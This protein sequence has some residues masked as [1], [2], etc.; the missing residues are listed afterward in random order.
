MKITEIKECRICKSLRLSRFFDFGEQYVVDFLDT[1]NSP[2]RGK[3][4]LCLMFCEDCSLVQLTHTVESDT[5]FKKFWYRSGINESMINALRDV[6]IKA[7]DFVHLEKGD[8]VLDIGANDGTLLSFYPRF[9]HAVAVDPARGFKEEALENLYVDEYIEDYFS[10][11]LL[12][13]RKFKIITA[14]AMFYDLNDPLAFMREIA[15]ALD[16][17]GVCVIQQNYLLSMLDNLAFD[18]IS[19]EHICYHTLKTMRYLAEKA[20]LVV[21][22]MEE[23]EVNGGSFRLYLAH[24]NKIE[25]VNKEYFLEP[26][27]SEEELLSE[28]S[29]YNM[30]FSKYEEIRDRLTTYIQDIVNKGGC[31]FGYGA[32]TRGTTLLQAIPEVANALEGV[33]DRDPHKVGKYMVSGTLPVVSEDAARQLATHFFVLPYHF[34]EPIIKREQQWIDEGGTMIIPLPYLQII[35]RRSA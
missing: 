14:I 12:P 21:F 17:K 35:T 2:T 6:V 4:P 31:I 19:H 11:S 7:E 23:N 22:K 10:A 18:N 5:L 15:K 9:V 32:S 28:L 33:A 13:D 24:K 20:G 8:S 25:Q 30:F 27:A 3:A 1:P 16:P 34:A 26:Y 29:T